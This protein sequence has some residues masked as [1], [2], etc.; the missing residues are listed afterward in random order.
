[1]IEEKLELIRPGQIRTRYSPSPTG[2]LHLGGVRTALFNFLFARKN[3]GKFI[4]RIEDTDVERSKK[5]YEKGI[6]ESLKWLSINWDE[7]PIAVAQN[8]KSKIKN[9][10][11]IGE[12]GPYRQSERL[13][14]YTKYLKKLLNEDKVYYCFC[15]KEDL[16]AEKQYQI[17]IGIAP[18]YSGKCADLA[19]STVK[20][21]LK[22]KKPA[23]IRLRV[24]LKIIEFED[25][26]RGK[27]KFDSSLMGDIIIAKDFTHPLYNFACAIDDYEMKI[28]NVIRGEDILSNTPK[29]ILLQEI[30]GFPHPKY[31]HI[32]LIFGTDGSKLSKRHGAKSI[33][34]YKKEGYLPEA[35]VNFIAFLGWNPGDEREIFSLNALI[36]DFSLK[37]IQKAPAIFNPTKLD[38][39]NGFYIRQKPIEKLTNLCLP[40]L[41]ADDLITA[42]F[43]TRQYPPAYGGIEISQKY[44]I[45]QTKEEI[46]FDFLKKIIAVEQERLKKISEIT[47]LADF[48]FKDKLNYEKKLLQWKNMSD[49]EIKSSFDRIIKTLSKIKDEDF[50]RETL[51]KILLPEA[52]KFAKEIGRVGDLS[53]D[54]AFVAEATSAKEAALAK[55]D[56]GYLLWPFRVAL[57]GKK[58]T[59]GPFE[60]A[61]ILG[62]KK[63]LKR[64]IRAHNILCAR[65]ST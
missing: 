62:K 54:S 23:T 50:N 4:L 59:A 24:P 32:P 10:K 37:K 53:A 61:E 26:I 28:T 6:L 19:K 51:E 57:T 60:I 21:Y 43:K 38:F 25:E 41:I 52:E 22:K 16:E 14:I 11:F 27:I 48:F 65:P 44:K 34:E 56:R 47:E 20:K 2:A 15:S 12:Y 36:R 35:I 55:A 49:K 13:D 64:I 39:L 46:S 9:Q 1:M 63:V 40:Y 42:V 5:Q 18:H 7:G 45:S 3:L 31:A 33:L 58:A 8:Q 17:S 29:Q 30:L